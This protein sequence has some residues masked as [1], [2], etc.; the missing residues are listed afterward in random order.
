MN[1]LI[2]ET[3]SFVAKQKEHPI[4]YRVDVIEHLL[5]G[6]SGRVAPA[7]P[8]LDLSVKQQWEAFNK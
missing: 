5:K 7:P 4:A 8:K 3:I 6:H 2:L 1:D